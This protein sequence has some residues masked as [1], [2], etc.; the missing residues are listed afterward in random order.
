MTKPELV[1]NVSEQLNVTQKEAEKYIDAVFE[2][3]K[4]GLIKDEKVSIYKTLTMELKDTKPRIGEVN[5][6]PYSTPA[7]KRIKVKVADAFLEDVI[8][9]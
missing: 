5:G 3:V 4:A 1:K 6:R 8:G 9:E 2:G 7:G